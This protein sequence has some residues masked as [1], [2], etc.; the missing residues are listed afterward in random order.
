MYRD[1]TS[2]PRIKKKTQ[3]T[4]AKVGASAFAAPPVVSA[5][6]EVHS[7]MKIPSLKRLSPRARTCAKLLIVAESAN[8]SYVLK[9]V[10]EKARTALR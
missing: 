5:E 10:T 1:Y 9:I 7:L 3:T 4:G 2:L 6:E 8:L